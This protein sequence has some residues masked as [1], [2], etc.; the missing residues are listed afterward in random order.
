MECEKGYVKKK[1]IMGVDGGGEINLLLDTP[2]VG[3][4]FGTS[5]KLGL[6]FSL[7]G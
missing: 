1:R 2:S 5:K 3:I 4:I 7:S 6:S